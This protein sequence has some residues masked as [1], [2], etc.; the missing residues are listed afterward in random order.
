VITMVAN[1]LCTLNVIVA[2]DTE[3]E[4]SSERS[5]LTLY[6]VYELCDKLNRNIKY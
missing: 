5:L 4:L 3:K 1:H 6:A 2:G